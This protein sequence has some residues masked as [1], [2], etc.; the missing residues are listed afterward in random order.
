MHT[1][2]AHRSPKD[3]YYGNL[4]NQFQKHGFGSSQD[5]HNIRYTGYWKNHKKHGTGKLI[6]PDGS[7]YIGIWKNGR[8][9]GKGQFYDAV[10]QHTITGEWST[11]R[12]TF[13]RRSSRHVQDLTE[14]LI[15]QQ[16]NKLSI[17]APTMKTFPIHDPRSV[18]VRPIPL[19]F[20]KKTSYIPLFAS[21]C[22][23]VIFC[24]GY[25]LFR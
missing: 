15:H 13:M 17:S 8:Y 19:S 4:N 23:P 3:T 22:L 9:T 24:I 10:N 2:F 14:E 16:Q 21:S 11:D 20:P 5:I 6:W 18:I 12:N 25:I 7:Y 1:T